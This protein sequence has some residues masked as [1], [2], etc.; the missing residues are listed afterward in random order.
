[1]TPT[2]TIL[3]FAN[4]GLAS[5]ELNLPEIS[6]IYSDFEQWRAAGLSRGLVPR[7]CQGYQHWELLNHQGSPI[8]EWHGDRVAGDGPE[9]L[10]TPPAGA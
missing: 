2:A 8:A 7:Q 4:T 3:T 1:L 9:F 10:P 5:S 6:M